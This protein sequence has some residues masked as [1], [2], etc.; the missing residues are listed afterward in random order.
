MIILTASP[1]KEQICNS[2]KY[3]S[4]ELAQISKQNS[5]ENLSYQMRYEWTTRS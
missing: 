5:F 1:N 2:Q 3:A 4:L